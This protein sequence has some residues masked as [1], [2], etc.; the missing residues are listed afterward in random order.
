ME[1]R[2]ISTLGT[3]RIVRRWS[4]KEKVFYER[5]AEMRVSPYKLKTSKTFHLIY[6]SHGDTRLKRNV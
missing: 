2:C 3:S 6:S 1:L 5:A 4:R